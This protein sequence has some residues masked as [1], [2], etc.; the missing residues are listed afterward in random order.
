MSTKTERITVTEKIGFGLGDAAANF[1]FQTIMFLQFDFYTKGFGI[2]A[3]TAGI[4]FLVG[5]LWG[6]VADP[7]MGGLGVAG[8]DPQPRQA[9]LGATRRETKRQPE[10]PLAT[11]RAERLPG[12]GNRACPKT[13]S[14]SAAGLPAGQRR[15][16]VL[17]RRLGRWSLRAPLPKKT[18]WPGPCRWDSWP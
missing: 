8:G 7:I 18:G 5:R 1:I 16:I 11:H 15:L 17:G 3:A 12:E 10:S 9:C 14:S 13:S 6:A 4:L 2:S